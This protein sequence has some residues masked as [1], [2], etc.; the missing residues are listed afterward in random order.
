MPFVPAV[1]GEAASGI[2][3]DHLFAEVVLDNAD[4][5]ADCQVR[6]EFDPSQ[7]CDAIIAA[8]ASRAG[9]KPVGE[10]IDDLNFLLPRFINPNEVSFQVSGV[11]RFSVLVRRTGPPGILTKATF[12]YDLGTVTARDLPAAS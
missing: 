8:Y 7:F 5:V 2:S 6:V 3:E 1:S 10:P 12:S 11:G 4:V 9:N